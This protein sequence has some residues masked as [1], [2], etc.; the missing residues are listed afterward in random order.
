MAA[1]SVIAERRVARVIGK[2][3][4]GYREALEFLAGKEIDERTPVKRLGCAA[5]RAAARDGSRQHALPDRLRELQRSAPRPSGRRRGAVHRLSLHRVRPRSEGVRVEL[6]KRAIMRELA[7]EAEGDGAVRGR[8]AP[9]SE[10][11]KLNGHG[12]SSCRPPASSRAPRDQGCGRG[13]GDPRRCALADRAFEALIAEKFVGR[14]ERELAW[15]LR[16]LLH[17]EGAD[18]VS[19]EAIV[20]SGPNGARPHAHPTDKIVE[21]RTRS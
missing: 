15:R 11:Q 7:R 14:T 1:D 18:D 19:F 2:G 10:W 20:A 16:E 4:D 5:R 6:L 8:R 13:G 21:G 3:P 17:A 12:A 9:V